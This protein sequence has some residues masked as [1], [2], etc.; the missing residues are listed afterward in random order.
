VLK[1]GRPGFDSLAESGQKTLK[2]GIHG[3]SVG[4][5]GQGKAVPPLNFCRWYW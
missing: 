3:M 5:W 1:V 4:S 2:V